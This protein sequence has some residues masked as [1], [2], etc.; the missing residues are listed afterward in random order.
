MDVKVDVPITL[1]GGSVSS[2][3]ELSRAPEKT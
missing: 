2:L 3:R 1:H